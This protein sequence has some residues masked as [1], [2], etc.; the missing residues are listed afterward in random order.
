LVALTTELTSATAAEAERLSGVYSTYRPALAALM[1]ERP[2]SLSRQLSS[3]PAAAAAANIY[4]FN[5]LN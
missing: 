5:R 4:A 2:H 1:V 3:S